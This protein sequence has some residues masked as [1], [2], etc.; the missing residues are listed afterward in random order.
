MSQDKRQDQFWFKSRGCINIVTFFYSF[1]THYIC[2]APLFEL[3]ETCRMLR[4]LCL[5]LRPDGQQQ[6]PESQVLGEG[7]AELWGGESVSFLLH[8]VYSN[9]VYSK[10]LHVYE[11]DPS[12]H[13]VWRSERK[14]ANQSQE[15]GHSDVNPTHLPVAKCADGGEA[16]YWYRNTSL[17][18]RK[19]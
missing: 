16:N 12:P 17:A 3:S 19:G 14:T 2:V 11:A 9:N 13:A 4:F 18:F 10:R 15:A 7:A 1:S 6:L 8:T 5:C